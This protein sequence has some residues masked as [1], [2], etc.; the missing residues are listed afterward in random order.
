M[1]SV[2]GGKSTEANG[3]LLK[4]IN[5]IWFNRQS[6]EKQEELNKLF[7]EY[8]NNFNNLKKIRIAKLTTEEIT[9]I[10]EIELPEIEEDYIEIPVEPITEEELKIYEENKKKRNEGVF[11]KFGDFER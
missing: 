8:K 2:V 7:Q 6:K 5:H 11:R 1:K 10:A 4:N 3:A 9:P